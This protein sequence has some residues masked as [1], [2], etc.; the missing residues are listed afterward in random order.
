MENASNALIIAG[1][2]LIGILIISTGVYLFSAYAQYSSNSYQKIENAKIEQFNSQFLKYY[3]NATASHIDANGKGHTITK[4]IDANGNEY[5]KETPILC[6]IHDI[7]S[8]ANLAKQNN[9]DLEVEE[10][11]RL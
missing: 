10:E 3:E 7:I 2:V 9:K 5:T 8:L 1:G 6:T 11:P 4:Y